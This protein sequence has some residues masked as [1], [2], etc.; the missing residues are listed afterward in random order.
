MD[1]ESA[2]QLIAETKRHAKDWD[3]YTAA[4]GRYPAN[5]SLALSLAGEL[6]AVLEERNGKLRPLIGAFTDPDECWFDHNGGCQAHG[7]ISL[8]PGEQCPH[9]ESK[10]WL[11]DNPEET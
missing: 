10:D 1:T 5:L 2:R 8:R 4:P 11:T 7:Y 9:R 3:T 6:E